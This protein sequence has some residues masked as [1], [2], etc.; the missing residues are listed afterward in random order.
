M[1]Y[2]NVKFITLLKEIYDTQTNL[3]LK[4]KR[5]IITL[6]FEFFRI[7]RKMFFFVLLHVTKKY[8]TNKDI[9]YILEYTYWI[10]Y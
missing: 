1:I 6:N 8:K 9:I 3:Y 5:F 2:S 10:S 4:L 7:F